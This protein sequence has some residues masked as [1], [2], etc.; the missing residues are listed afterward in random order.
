ML[1]L[2][3]VRPNILLGVVGGETGYFLFANHSFRCYTFIIILIFIY[4][5]FYLFISVL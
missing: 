2:K 1:N 5:L 4:E 3:V